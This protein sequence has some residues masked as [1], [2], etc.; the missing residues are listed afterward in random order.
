MVVHAPSQVAAA[1]EPPKPGTVMH[2]F[3]GDWNDSFGAIGFRY[4]SPDMGSAALADY[5]A[6]NLT[7]DA[8]A[9]YY[10]GGYDD[11]P[12][13]TGKQIACTQGGPDHIVGRYV[14][15]TTGQGR[16]DFSLTYAAGQT[17]TFSGSYTPDG[18]VRHDWRGTFKSHFDGDGC[19]TAPAIETTRAYRI[20]LG[21]DDPA[22]TDFRA[23]AQ[24]A[25]SGYL[26]QAT[27][28]PDVT[29]ETVVPGQATL[30][31]HS[32][33]WYLSPRNDLYD[34][35]ALDVPPQQQA[36]DG[37]VFARAT[38]YDERQLRTA[39]IKG[40]GLILPGDLLTMA[41]QITGGRYPLAVLTAHN[42]LK[43]VALT[44]RDAIT[45]AHNDGTSH[46]FQAQY[47][48]SFPDYLATLQEQNKVVAKLQS[49]R[50]NPGSP[51]ARDKLGPWY[52]AFA[53][54]TMGALN[55]PSDAMTMVLLEHGTKYVNGF[56][57]EGGF[58]QEKFALDRC[59]AI[60]S[61]QPALQ[62]L[63]QTVLPQRTTP[64][65][66]CLSGLQ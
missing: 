57:N 44:G 37:N 47:V 8:D 65:Q 11:G 4:V 61:S 53:V 3:S 24:F 64:I 25:L 59:W 29:N 5:D 22:K 31:K 21:L 35:L 39:I 45:Y 19:C 23:F 62:K 41:L 18:G 51:S 13:Q 63:D 7:C 14:G 33:R 46:R 30:G 16:G 55:G 20:F 60:L 26:R 54:M 17:P 32:K 27:T 10:Q 2:V 52:H 58:N 34:L 36:K 6:Q 28:F 12:G 40:R 15:D 1:P 42:L 43:G 38:T 9:D 56:L 49:L 66:N 50:H 48:L